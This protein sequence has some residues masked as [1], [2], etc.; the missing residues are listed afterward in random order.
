M[1]G[2]RRGHGEGSIYRRKDGVWSAAVDLG[3]KDGKRRRKVVYGK[4]QAEV[5]DR[6][7][8]LQWK[9]NVGVAPP[10]ERLTVGA[11]LNVW[12]E[13]LLPVR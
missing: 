7:R 12:L 2:K 5:R 4:T 10:P 13:E 8:E 9:L 6:L 1:T 3:N 11:F